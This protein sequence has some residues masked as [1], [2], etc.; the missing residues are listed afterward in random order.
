M[1]QMA[2]PWPM[3]RSTSQTPPQPLDRRGQR[4]VR[5]A[6]PQ[7]LQL[8]QQRRGPQVRTSSAG[9]GYDAD[10]LAVDGNPLSDPAALHAIRAVYVRGGAG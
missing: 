4:L 7:R 10:I 5:T 8:I 6:V 1:P 3:T 2:G 9:P